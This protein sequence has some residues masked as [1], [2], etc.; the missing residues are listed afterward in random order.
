M[1]RPCHLYTRSGASQMTISSWFGEPA[2]N[3]TVSHASCFTVEIGYVSALRPLRWFGDTAD[4]DVLV[5]GTCRQRYLMLPTWYFGVDAPAVRQ[6]V[7]LLCQ[8]QSHCEQVI[9]TLQSLPHILF[10]IFWKFC[11]LSHTITFLSRF[12][13]RYFY[14]SLNRG[15]SME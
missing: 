5:R 12:A 2:D 4:N 6:V 1:Y 13:C 3:G 15:G 10:F 7:I 14:T 9:S 8:S 11:M